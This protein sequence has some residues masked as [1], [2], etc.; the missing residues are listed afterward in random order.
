ML[1]AHATSLI[2]LNKYLLKKLFG[3]IPNMLGTSTFFSASSL[4]DSSGMHS[5]AFTSVP[6]TKAS[7]ESSC[8]L[9]VCH[10]CQIHQFV[11]SY[12]LQP[13]YDIANPE[14]DTICI[15][16][17]NLQTKN[18]HCKIVT[19]GLGGFGSGGPTFTKKSSFP[20]L[21]DSLRH[22]RT[23]PLAMTCL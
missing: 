7:A 12:K 22:P 1:W 19:A 3:L 11:L 23:A 2:V 4:T 17:N 8:H 20:G 10:L 18:S 13:A 6:S 21:T 14:D 9:T 15:L 5:N 16:P